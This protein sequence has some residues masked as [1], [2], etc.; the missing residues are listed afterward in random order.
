MAFQ[1]K[2]SERIRIPKQVNADP[3]LSLAIRQLAARNMRTIGAE[4]VRLLMVG[5]VNDISLGVYE[6]FRINAQQMAPKRTVTHINAQRK[7]S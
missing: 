6:Q 5:I 1:G 4:I 2:R 3:E 7:A